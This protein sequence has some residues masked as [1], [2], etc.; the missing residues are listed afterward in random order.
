MLCNNI[1]DN[2]LG[3]RPWLWR[4]CR[5]EVDAVEAIW[6]CRP[7][8]CSPRVTSQSACSCPGDP[9]PPPAL[10]LPGLWGL[11]TA[12]LH[13]RLCAL[14]QSLTSCQKCKSACPC[15]GGPSRVLS[16]PY[17]E[18]PPPTSC[19]APA[20]GDPSVLLS[21]PCPGGRLPPPVLPL[22]WGSPPTSCLGPALRDPSHLLSCPCPGGPFPPPVLPLPLGTPPT[23]CLAP[24]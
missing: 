18:G 13:T 20:L 2:K 5:L 17:P 11:L 22:P 10:P 4:A 3:N 15:P 1:K 21:C 16:C 19:L 8:S 7:P 9:L 12:H 14:G 24:A 6:A 23:S